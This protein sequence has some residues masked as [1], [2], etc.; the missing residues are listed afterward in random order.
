MVGPSSK[1]KVRP[2]E[3][4]CSMCHREHHSSS[5]TR[6]RLNSS[7]ERLFL[8]WPITAPQSVIAGTNSPDEPPMV[9]L[10]GE[11]GVRESRAGSAGVEC[12]TM[13]TKDA[14]D[15]VLS[16]SPVR[17]PAGHGRNGVRCS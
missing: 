13:E 16:A 9:Q 2:G 15:C 5:F 6:P 8:P 12:A 17:G 1:G 11:Y 14:G 3:V 10:H 4:W 7:D